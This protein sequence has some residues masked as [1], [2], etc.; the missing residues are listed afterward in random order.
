MARLLL[1]SLLSLV[2]YG[3]LSASCAALTIQ[4]LLWVVPDGKQSDLA[5]TSTSGQTIPLSWNGGVN[6]TIDNLW[7]ATL[8][9]HLN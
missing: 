8:E 3:L 2:L 5:Q 4:Q 9:Y 1:Q 6:T 7:A